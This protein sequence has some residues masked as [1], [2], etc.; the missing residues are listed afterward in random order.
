MC[1]HLLRSEK[2]SCRKQKAL[3]PVRNPQLVRHGFRLFPWLCLW[4]RLKYF[5]FIISKVNSPA[6]P[7]LTKQSLAWLCSALSFAFSSP[8][9]SSSLGCWQN[10]FVFSVFV[11]GLNVQISHFFQTHY[12][13]A[14]SLR[15]IAASVDTNNFWSILHVGKTTECISKTLL[16]NAVYGDFFVFSRC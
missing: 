13:C 2:A 7:R 9:A 8:C 15:I 11:V 5:S 3:F 4:K 14:E 12:N 10:L 16:W 1:L 6:A